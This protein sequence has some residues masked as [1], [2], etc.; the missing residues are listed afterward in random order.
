MAR[1]RGDPSSIARTQERLQQQVQDQFDYQERCQSNEER[2]K[3]GRHEGMPI[4]G[5]L[6]RADAVR[7]TRTSGP[8]LSVVLGPSADEVRRKRVVTLPC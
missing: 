2:H 3:F 7:D 8:L 6:E 1:K 5:P 4:D